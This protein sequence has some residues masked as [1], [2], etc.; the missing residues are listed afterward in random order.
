MFCMENNRKLHLFL[1]QLEAFNI[2]NRQILNPK[3]K[4]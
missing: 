1:I 3:L 4:S 2:K